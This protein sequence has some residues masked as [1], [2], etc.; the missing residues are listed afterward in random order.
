MRKSALQLRPL[1]PRKYVE[2]GPRRHYLTERRSMRIE[3]LIRKQHGKPLETDDDEEGDEE[4]DE[5]YN[6]Y[7]LGGGDEKN[8]YTE[9][10]DPADDIGQGERGFRECSLW[11]DKRKEFE[12]MLHAAFTDRDGVL[13]HDRDLDTRISIPRI[14]FLWYQRIRGRVG[15]FGDELLMLVFFATARASIA[16]G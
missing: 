7:F 11:E 9:E 10:E 1:R 6:I 16:L 8:K 13:Y 2:S 4:E 5:E 12:D 15:R 3:K 14:T